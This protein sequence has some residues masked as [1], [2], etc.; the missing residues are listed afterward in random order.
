MLARGKWT[1]GRERIVWNL[2]YVALMFQRFWS[3]ENVFQSRERIKFHNLD[4]YP[5]NAHC[6]FRRLYVSELCRSSKVR[7]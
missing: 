4:S 1:G 6:R 7:S 3:N 2:L 5:R